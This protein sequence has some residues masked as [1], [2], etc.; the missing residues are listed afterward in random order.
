MPSRDELQ[1]RLS[2]RRR[3]RHPPCI[4]AQIL[5]GG[6][7]HKITEERINGILGMMK[8]P[9][10]N[11]D[12]E[13]EVVPTM[14][15]CRVRYSKALKVYLHG[16]DRRIQLNGIAPMIA[17]QIVK[18]R[19]TAQPGHEPG[20]LCAPPRPPSP[21]CDGEQWQTG[22][23]ERE[24][25]R[26]KRELQSIIARVSQANNAQAARELAE[27]REAR[28]VEEFD[29]A[30][31]S[32][33]SANDQLETE[34]RERIANDQRIVQLRSELERC[35][36]SVAVYKSRVDESEERVGDLMTSWKGARREK[37]E[38]LNEAEYHRQLGGGDRFKLTEGDERVIASCR[39]KSR[40]DP[41]LQEEVR[42]VSILIYLSD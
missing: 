2:G 19:T 28:S 35:E 20:G 42:R 1:P 12:W 11:A 24:M 26:L 39:E 23:E 37:E 27:D 36:A 5:Q 21:G 9:Q 18:S 32:F 17:E 31:L 10:P 6:R 34:N 22:D 38:V 40:F 33:R 41:A 29:R 25:E 8:P 4:P 14:L 3:Q 16:D 13:G 7:Q 30:A 15:Q